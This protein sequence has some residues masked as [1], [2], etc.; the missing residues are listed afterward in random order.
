MKNP[1]KC[2]NCGDETNFKNAVGEREALGWCAPCFQYRQKHLRE[3]NDGSTY[4][5]D[6]PGDIVRKTPFDSRQRE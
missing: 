6:N 5:V 4:W 2:K 3:R 1:V